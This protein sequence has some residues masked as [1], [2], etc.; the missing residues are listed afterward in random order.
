MKNWIENEWEKI[1]MMK[2]TSDEFMFSSMLRRRQ[3]HQYEEKLY[4]TSLNSLYI[5]RNGKI[6]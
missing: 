2:R 1:M 4:D 6:L 3:H 5:K